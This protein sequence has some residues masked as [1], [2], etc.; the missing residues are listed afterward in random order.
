MRRRT[1]DTVAEH[2]IGLFLA[3]AVDVGVVDIPFRVAE[4]G[5]VCEA[6]SGRNHMAHSADGTL[7]KSHHAVYLGGEVARQVEVDEVAETMYGVGLQVASRVGVV[8]PL[9]LDM[10]EIHVVVETGRV[11]P[12]EVL[13]ELDGQVDGDVVFDACLGVVAHYVFGPLA[14]IVVEAVEQHRVDIVEKDF[15]VHRIADI[16]L[17]VPTFFAH[18]AEFLQGI[19]AID[20]QSQLGQRGGDL[21][22]HRV[23]AVAGIEGEIDLSTEV[24]LVGNTR[25]EGVAQLFVGR[26]GIVLVEVGADDIDVSREVASWVSFGVLFVGPLNLE[27]VAFL[28]VGGAFCAN[29]VD[30]EAQSQ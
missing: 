30:G 10:G 8:Y 28:I 21:S 19:E 11:G 7:G 25:L 14:E 24:G 23:L 27:V 26:R 9:F 1:K 6:D 2:V 29:L 22:R 4:V 20:G 15:A 18:L 17:L 3:V 13:E 12:G 5:F 16:Q